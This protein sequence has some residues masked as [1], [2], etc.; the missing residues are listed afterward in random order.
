MLNEAKQVITAKL[1][2]PKCGK[3]KLIRIDRKDFKSREI[4]GL[5]KLVFHHGDHVFAVW[6]DANGT[7]RS[8]EVYNVSGEKKKY[9]TYELFSIEDLIQVLDLSTLSRIIAATLGKMKII[10]GFQGKKRSL[11]EFLF[12]N[13]IGEFPIISDGATDN[14]IIRIEN[15]SP[16]QEIPGERYFKRVIQRAIMLRDIESQYLRLQIAIDRVKGLAE[17]IKTEIVN[18]HG[19]TSLLSLR[20]KFDVG[21]DDLLKLAILRVINVDSKNINKIREKRYFLPFF[22]NL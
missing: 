21:D 9:R 7:Q 4:G 20:R 10:M 14:H 1:K 19:V 15:I 8:V 17:S 18:S 2:C 22:W 13:V 3:V 11:L 12:S 16:H 6:V 5:I